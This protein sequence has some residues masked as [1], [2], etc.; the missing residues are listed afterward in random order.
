MSQWLLRTWVLC[1]WRSGGGGGSCGNEENFTTV[2]NVR[3]SIC[4]LWEYMVSPL[5][6][7]PLCCLS[8]FRI[9]AS[10]DRHSLHQCQ[11][12]GLYTHD[13]CSCL[14]DAVCDPACVHGGVLT[15]HYFCFV[16]LNRTVPLFPEL[17][18]A[19]SLPFFFWYSYF[20]FI[21]FSIFTVMGCGAIEATGL[22]FVCFVA[23]N[24]R[25]LSAD[26]V[27]S[28]F[29]CF[30]NFPISPPPPQDTV[31]VGSVC[32]TLAT[33]RRT[34][35]APSYLVL[36]PASSMVGVMIRGSLRS[37]KRLNNFSINPWKI[38]IF[39]RSFPGL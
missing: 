25:V 14:P 18:F 8:S 13:D 35:A 16:F 11:C 5:Y 33:L 30:I 10:F 31:N 17:I 29:F 1:L 3:F 38:S 28:G 22:G 21:Q 23:I 4:Y 20:L 32:V 12:D 15:Q 7:K 26:R 2:K 19:L 37:P 24:P 9:F 34:A 39:D 27:D 6:T 36:R